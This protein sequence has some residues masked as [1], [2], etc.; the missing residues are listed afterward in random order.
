MKTYA[1]RSTVPNPK[2]AVIRSSRSGQV[3]AHAYQA[4]VHDQSL[5]PMTLGQ[6]SGGIYLS[7]RA[8]PCAK[9]TV[10]L[11]MA[12]L[13][14]KS[15]LIVDDAPSHTA[16]VRTARVCAPAIARLPATSSWKGLLYRH[17]DYLIDALNHL[18][19]CCERL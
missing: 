13:R 16:S 5:Q 11:E 15:W 3:Q 10:T 2:P 9:S 6:S 17:S 1:A 14:Q 7:I 12:T 8:W 19:P 18:G 4:L